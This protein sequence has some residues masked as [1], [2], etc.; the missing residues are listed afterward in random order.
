MQI[1]ERMFQIMEQKN[2]KAVQLADKLGISKG[3]ISNWKKRKTNPPIEYAVLICEL[4][5]VD[6]EYFIT[7]KERDD[8]LE[9]T[10]K[11]KEMLQHF[12]KLSRDG[13]IET[14]GFVKGK[15]SEQVTTEQTKQKL[16]I[17]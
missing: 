7:G 3:V 2:I 11:E 17:S 1:Y 8:N 4:L 5:G 16:L 15:L 9:L 13:Q 12:R 10:E 14:I 6:I